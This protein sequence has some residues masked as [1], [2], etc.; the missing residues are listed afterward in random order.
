MLRGGGDKKDGDAAGASQGHTDRRM[1][2]SRETLEAVRRRESDALAETFE[3][4]F[5]KVYSLAYRLTG[6]HAAAEDVAQEVFLK[7][8]NAAHQID[9]SRD[10]GPWLTAITCN[11]CRE[12]WRSRGHRLFSRSNSLNGNVAQKDRLVNGRRNP[13]Q[14]AE[15]TERETL[16][17]KALMKLPKD[18]R[19]V[20]VLHDYQ[21]HS[22]EE[23]AELTKTGYAAVRKRYSRAL[24]RLKDELKD[25][26]E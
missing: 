17:M 3:R 15:A 26:L 13:E 10:I 5:G 18:M 2:L 1:Q 11:A 22:H 16:V 25:V 4:C 6:E 9:P 21:G 7:L 8:Y 12:R 14:S 23:I 24:A 20:V 19:T